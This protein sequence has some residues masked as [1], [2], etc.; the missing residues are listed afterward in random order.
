MML[1]E[2]ISFSVIM[3]VIEGSSV[4]VLPGGNVTLSCSI[5]VDKE[6]TWIITNGNQTFVRIMRLEYGYGPEPKLEPSNIHPSYTDRIRAL[7]SSTNTHSLLLM[8]IT[9]T[10]LMLYCCTD[11]SIGQTECTKLDYEEQHNTE[12]DTKAIWNYIIN[13]ICL[14]V[15]CVLLLLSLMSNVCMCWRIKRPKKDNLKELKTLHKSTQDKQGNE[16]G[17]IKYASVNIKK[18]QRNR[19]QHHPT[20]DTVYACIK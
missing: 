4:K 17:E 5:K 15:I 16:A 6:T 10:D 9:D 20:Q 12:E 7:S 8:N 11:Y 3:I 19:G 13:T 14:P 2:L 1:R 18:V